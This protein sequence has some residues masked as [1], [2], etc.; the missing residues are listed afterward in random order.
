MGRVANLTLRQTGGEGAWFGVDIT[1][2]RLELESCDIAS[3]SLAGV[4]IRNGADPRLHRNQIHGQ[5]E[6][7]AGVFVYDSGLGTLEDNDITSNGR[8]GMEI[9]TGGNPTVRRN[10][11][12]RNTFE[13]VWIYEGGGGVIE[14][15]DL[16][17]NKLGPWDIDKDSQ[18]NVKRRGNRR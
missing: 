2:G 13:A 6:G 18:P 8:A 4:A 1:Q 9:I 11:I 5:G 14:D 3:Q 12:N 10:R 16:T 7:S 15:N 17:G